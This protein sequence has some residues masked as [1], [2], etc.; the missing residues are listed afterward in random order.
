MLGAGSAEF[1]EYYRQRRTE[2]NWVV[3]YVLYLKTSWAKQGNTR[4]QLIGFPLNLYYILCQVCVPKNVPPLRYLSNPKN[5]HTKC[6]AP[7]KFDLIIK[8]PNIVVC[9]VGF[10]VLLSQAN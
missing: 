7:K 4:D 8:C 6:F 9:S 3:R 10:H 2:L 5:F 1:G